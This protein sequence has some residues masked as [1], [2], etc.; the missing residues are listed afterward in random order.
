M[1][2]LIIVS[3]R[4]PVII[5][6]RKN[7]L[8]FEPSVGGLATGL[9]SFHK[10]YNSVWIGWPGIDSEKI[11][12]SEEE[13][14]KT[15]LRSENCYPV[16]LSQNDVEDYYHG[17]C[18]RTIWPLFH[19]F[20]DHA[21]YKEDSWQAYE[22][23]NEA[24]SNA[25]VEVAEPGD[26]IWVHDY[27]LMLLPGFLRQRL[28]EAI[29]GFFL[30]IPFPSFETF[31]LLPWRKQILNGLLG[32]DLIGFHTYDYTRH[33][34]NSV[35]RLLGYEAVMG[36]ITTPDRVI[37]ADVFPMG[38][39]YK[40]YSSAAQGSKVRAEI[41]KFRQKL[42]NRT[43]ILSIDRLDYTKGIPQRL[44]AFSVFLERHP[45]YK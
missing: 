8:Y 2:R 15:R 14:I 36:Q 21:V 45:E 17:F 24:F 12:G 37:R 19:Y 1:Q 28:S 41:T 11:K 42:G 33:F 9:V 16:F 34:I 30:H 27:Q 18:N 32:S 43:I 38:I 39:D 31:R 26:I 10:S 25:V 44:E 6:K 35:H 29:V 4:L 22:R 23:V 20:T 13:E 5:E 7:E 3:N 40:R